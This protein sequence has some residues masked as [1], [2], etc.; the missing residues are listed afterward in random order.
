MK[1]R[2]E[3]IMRSF[4]QILVILVV[5]VGMA[6][7]SAARAEN[8]TWT[9]DGIEYRIPKPVE[10]LELP[11]DIPESHTVVTGDTLWGIS[12]AYL[13]DPYLWPLV[14]EENLDTIQNPHRIYPGDIVKL[15]GGTLIAADTVPPEQAAVMDDMREQAWDE[16][17]DADTMITPFDETTRTVRSRKPFAVLTE[18][19]LIASGLISPEKISGPEIIAAETTAFDL[20][21]HDVIFVRG[22]SKD[23]LRPGET[24]F[25]MREMHK[26]THPLSG[27]YLGR[28]Y[29]VMAEAEILCVGDDVTSAIIEKSYHAV[30]RGDFLVPGEDIPMPVTMGSPPFDRCNPSTKTLPGS[31]V[32]AFIGNPDFTDAVIIAQGD[33]AY[34]DLGSQDGV[35]PG[36]FFAIFTRDT[37]DQSLP[38]FVSGELMVVK[39]METTSVAVITHS[40]TAIFLGDSIELK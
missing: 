3:S 29:H 7:L 11:A 17:E 15:P 31:I 34:I 10:E 2:G 4:K 18:A 20:A 9:Y 6:G 19:D 25:I 28:M 8:K 40:N 30:L 36:D 32:D 37:N 38:R 5:F 14:W 24:Y 35:A 22:G 26:V 23:N 27:R 39:V 16:G 21:S 12:R 33:V 1:G 13:N